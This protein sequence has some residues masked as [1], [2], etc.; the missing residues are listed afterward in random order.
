MAT[1]EARD[2]G[3]LGALEHD[4]DKD[5]ALGSD[6]STYTQT[7]RSSLLDS[8][9]ENGRSYHKYH[10]GSYILP[11]DEQEQMR[12]D[13]QHEMFMRTFDRKLILAP[14]QEEAVGNVRK[15]RC[16]SRRVEVVD[17]AFPKSILEQARVSGPSSSQTSIPKQRSSAPISVLCSQP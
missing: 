8:V 9:K 6:E 5:S 2:E 16:C 13:I 14:I 4:D 10:D 7:L 17:C 12:L 3:S 1:A 11:E 15:F